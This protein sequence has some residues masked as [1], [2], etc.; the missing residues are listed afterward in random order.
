MSVAESIVIFAP[1]VQVGMPQR[2][3]GRHGPQLVG[4][5]PP[6]RP[7]G[8]GQD[9][10]RH[11]LRRH[12]RH[13]LEHRRVL[14]VDRDQRG[15]RA[16]P[17]GRDEVAAGHQALLVRERH[18]NPAVER[19]QRRPQARRAHEGVQD[20]VGL[21]GVD[22]RR[23]GGVVRHGPA[24]GRAGGVAHAVGRR[25]GVHLGQASAAGEPAGLQ[26]AGRRDDLEGLNPDGSGG[27]Q[28]EYACHRASV[29][30]RPR[31][32]TEDR[33]RP[34]GVPSWPVLILIAVAFV[35]GVGDRPL[36][37]RSPGAAGGAGRLGRRG[38]APRGGHRSG[39]RR[40]VRHLHARARP[41]PADPGLSP[42]AMRDWPSRP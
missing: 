14:E 40:V 30:R 38:H 33:P 32:P 8:S 41:G 7:P 26:I 13:E 3:G 9:P 5:P 4:G 10:R 34:A 1:I 19:R 6:E 39:L 11:P 23:E 2:V 37:L 21:R 20:Q 42:D 31:T 29:A 27:P 28:D 18:G 35:A 16:G 12:A 24:A 17:R 36:A 22:E 15:A 25:L